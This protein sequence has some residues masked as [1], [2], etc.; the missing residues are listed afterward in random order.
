MSVGPRGRQTG[1]SPTVPFHFITLM[2]FKVY[3]PKWQ[4]TLPLITAGVCVC[5]Q[6]RG[7]LLGR[8]VHKT[9]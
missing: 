5:K 2:S 1:C 4:K 6:R 9:L 8:I 7:C 3:G